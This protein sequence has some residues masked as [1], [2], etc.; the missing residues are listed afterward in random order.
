[1]ESMIDGCLFKPAL[2]NYNDGEHNASSTV[3]TKNSD[4]CTYYYC[5]TVPT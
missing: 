3:P 5:H 1:M 4:S 2:F